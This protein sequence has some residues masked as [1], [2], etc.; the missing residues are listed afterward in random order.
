MI[1]RSFRMGLRL[2]V[3]GGTAFAVLKAIQS[4]RETV[5]PELSPDWHW[6]PPAPLP[7][8]EPEPKVEAE[9]KPEPMPSPKLTVVATPAADTADGAKA[10]A[11]EAAEVGQATVAP[12]LP[13][14]PKK[15]TTPRKRAPAQKWVEPT[16]SVCPASHPVKAKLSSRLFH[17]PGMFAYARTRPDRCYKDEAAALA[18]GL[19]KAKR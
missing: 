14:R 11:A 16:G 10:D 13:V 17:L 19:V 9:P 12:A 5:T 2:G 4:R 8:L 15:A 6:E 1:S 7:K 3:V 18:D